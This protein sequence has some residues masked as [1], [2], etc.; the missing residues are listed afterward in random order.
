MSRLSAETLTIEGPD[1]LAFAHSQLG[2][3]VH[4]LAVGTWQW[5]VWLNPQGRVRALL[6]LMH[7][8]EN[9]LLALLRGG[10][11][12]ALAKAIAPYLMRAKAT[13]TAHPV[14]TLADAA[15]LPSG[16]MHANDD[17]LTLG[18]GDYAMCIVPASDDVPQD[19][20]R[21]AIEAGHPWLPDNTLDR[22]LAPALRSGE[23]GATRLDKGC[24]PGQEIVA[25][26][27]YRGGCPQHLRR[28]QSDAPLP[29]GCPLSVDGHNIGMVLDSVR[30]ERHTVALA[31]IRDT[32][33]A[34]EITARVGDT[35]ENSRLVSA[36]MPSSTKRTGD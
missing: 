5:S 16:A 4:E 11:A 30:S 32:T 27:H 33:P 34:G 17:A 2:S 35:G 31:V 9:T 25:R 10:S 6:Q 21:H 1:A 15:P 24:Y 12:D 26:L 23:L 7:P 14:R 20:R 3:H 8:R 18:M 19:W 29:A 22:L 28:V 13:V 36:L